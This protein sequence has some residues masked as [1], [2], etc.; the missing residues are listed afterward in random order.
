MEMNTRHTYMRPINIRSDIIWSC[1]GVL[2]GAAAIILACF[3]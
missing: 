1:V 2:A 3:L